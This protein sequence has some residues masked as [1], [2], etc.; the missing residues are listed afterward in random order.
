MPTSDVTSTTQRRLTTTHSALSAGD[1]HGSGHKCRKCDSLLCLWYT[2]CRETRTF[3]LCCGYLE[4]RHE[5]LK[6]VS[7]LPEWAAPVASRVRSL[8]S[9]TAS[10]PCPTLPLSSVS[11]VFVVRE[12]QT[13][14]PGPTSAPGLPYSEITASDSSRP[15]L[16]MC[17][18]QAAIKQPQQ[19]HAPLSPTIRRPVVTSCSRHRCWSS[20]KA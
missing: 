18:Y 15:P 11:K 3:L 8:D 4:P 20:C 7:K 14:A 2:S 19:R 9:C 5:G 6:R 17:I 12:A 1:K 10:I 13:L 16:L